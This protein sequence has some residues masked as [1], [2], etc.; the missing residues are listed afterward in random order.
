[1]SVVKIEITVDASNVGAVQKFLGELAQDDK[2]VKNIEVIEPEE[3][4]TETV[5]APAK[6]SSRAKP[7]EEEPEY[8]ME[9]GEDA[10]DPGTDEQEGVDAED[11]KLMQAKKVTAHRDAIIDKLKKLGAK[12]I[13]TLDPEH[14]QEYYDFLAKLK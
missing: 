12:G 5:K 13:S 9:L 10:E 2:K 7:K 11:I 1:M 14:F 3:V 8:E 6:R 4:K